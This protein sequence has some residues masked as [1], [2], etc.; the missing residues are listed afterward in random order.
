MNV[1]GLHLN[2]LKMSTGWELLAA[3][4]TWRHLH[5]PAV[6]LHTQAAGAFLLRHVRVGED[7]SHCW[8]HIGNQQQKQHPEF[9]KLTHRE[10]IR[11]E[12]QK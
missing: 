5:L 1:R 10:S 11:A 4:M 7:A 8:S 2:H 3:S 12:A 9:A 6:V